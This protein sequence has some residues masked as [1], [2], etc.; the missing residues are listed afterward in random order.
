MGVLTDRLTALIDEY[1]G[2]DWAS[3]EE[4]LA[5]LALR[6]DSVPSTREL[7]TLSGMG[8]RG[9]SRLILRL[10]A[11]DVVVATRT[12]SDRRKT[13]VEVT[14]KG[15]RRFRA[16]DGDVD[17]VFEQL[18]GTVTEL[19]TLLR[20]DLLNPIDTT[21]GA[22]R[23][24]L[25]IVESIAEIGVRV[26]TALATI[27][28]GATVSGRQRSALIQIVAGPIARPVDLGSTLN[29]S[30]SGVTAVV[31]QLVAKDLVERRRGAVADDR[32]AVI[33]SPTAAGCRVAAK[34]ELVMAGEK[35]NLLAVVTAIL[36]RLDALGS[37]LD[38]DP[39]F[40][41]APTESMPT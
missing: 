37:Q 15:R 12:L 3:N 1:F 24:P 6:N 11:D 34:V 29:E 28:D 30:R 8:R 35:A 17:R 14:P 13:S 32:R 4:V 5:L 38:T 7:S 19:H 27:A 26:D 10:R 25:T 31:D 20:K 22:G 40:W 39:E 18:R 16:L 41:V 9:V 33:I 2:S 21:V 36:N 23:D